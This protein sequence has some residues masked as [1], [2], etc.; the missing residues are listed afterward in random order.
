MLII[1][2]LFR[3]NV[4][5]SKLCLNFSLIHLFGFQKSFFYCS[6]VQFFQITF[7][8]N[9]TKQCLCLSPFI[10]LYA[11]ATWKINENKSKQLKGLNFPG[12][13]NSQFCRLVIHR[14][15]HLLKPVRIYLMYKII[16]KSKCAKKTMNCA[17]IALNHIK[18]N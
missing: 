2:Q 17:F 14:S 15:R 4:E 7:I 6:V 16:L 11:A 9:L 3:F 10:I 18:T 13:Q 1:S 5:Q 8:N 12:S